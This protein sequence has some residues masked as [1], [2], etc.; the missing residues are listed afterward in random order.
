MSDEHHLPIAA[1]EGLFD[2]MADTSQ[3]ALPKDP[4]AR[5]IGRPIGRAG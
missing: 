5:V 3:M 2:V 1:D 4:L